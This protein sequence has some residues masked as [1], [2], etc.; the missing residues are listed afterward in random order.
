[1]IQICNFIGAL[2]DGIDECIDNNFTKTL[3]KAVFLLAFNSF[4]R[5]GEILVRSPKEAGSVIQK[6]DVSFTYCNRRPQSITLVIRHYKSI[7]NNQPVTITIE[8][9]HNNLQLCPVRA[10]HSHLENHSRVDVLLFLCIGGTPVTHSYVTGQLTF[11]LKYLGIDPKFFKAHSF[12]IGA[13]THATTLGFSEPYIR[14]LGRWNSNAVQRY[15]RI[16]SFNL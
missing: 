5:L 15:I 1:V 11:I 2:F 16:S 14:Q 9:N 10:V 6:Q 3:L 4:L 12:R 7:K 8:A 13:A